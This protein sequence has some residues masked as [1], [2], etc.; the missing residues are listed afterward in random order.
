M[1]RTAV[2]AAF[3]ISGCSAAAL[4]V[5]WPTAVV[6]GAETAAMVSACFTLTEGMDCGAFV[7]AAIDAAE[8]SLDVQAY[9]F[10]AHDIIAAIVRAKA[11]GVAVR[12]ILDKI[13]PSQ[14]C[15]G[16]D[17]VRD[18]GIPVY[19]DRKPKIAHNKVMILDSRAV[20]TGS[21]NFSANAEKSNAENTNLIAS[22]AIAAQYERNF[23]NRLA[24][25][26][27][28]DGVHRKPVKPCAVAEDEDVALD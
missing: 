13:S 24:V 12:V 21:L 6:A 17:P 16:A 9:N 26:T 8:I 3:L 19:I 27:P 4:A 20:I 15:E 14:M 11:R 1:I 10:T 25:S 18:A 28:W 22:P 23:L 2:F 5:N 7:V